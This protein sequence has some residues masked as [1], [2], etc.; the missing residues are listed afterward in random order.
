MSHPDKLCKND[1]ALRKEQNFGDYFWIDY[2]KLI[3]HATWH[4]STDFPT[5]TLSF[6]SL[7]FDGALANVNQVYLVNTTGNR[8]DIDNTDLEIKVF[9]GWDTA[10]IEVTFKVGYSL[11]PLVYVTSPLVT[12]NFRECE[13]MPNNIP[14]LDNQYVE[15]GELA[16]FKVNDTNFDHMDAWCYP[17]KKFLFENIGTG[18]VSVGDPSWV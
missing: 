6:S 13:K 7:L 16:Y 18:P 15:V 10:R 12:L 3:D 4:N 1:F 11:L 5:D 14:F 9:S 2:D 8:F 17:Y